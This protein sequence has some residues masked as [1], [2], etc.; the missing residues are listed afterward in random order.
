[1]IVL[2]AEVILANILS[3][4]DFDYGVD[5]NVLMEYCQLVKKEISKTPMKSEYIYFDISNQSINN[6]VKY[7]HEIFIKINKRIFAYGEVNVEYF[8]SRLDAEI[9]DSLMKANETF[10]KE[11]VR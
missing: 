6:A 9:V 2:E 5:S 8:N 11:M 4:V 10:N 7:Y 3:K 1:M